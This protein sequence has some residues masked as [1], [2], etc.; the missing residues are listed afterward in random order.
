M[1]RILLM[2]VLKIGRSPRRFMP[3]E[4]LAMVVSW[5]GVA[6]SGVAALCCLLLI[7]ST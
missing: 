4:I 1:R 5:L 3:A 2:V 6:V 7:S